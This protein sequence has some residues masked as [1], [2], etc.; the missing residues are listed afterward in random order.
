MA[1]GLSQKSAFL[2]KLRQHSS[3]TDLPVP[4]HLSMSPASTSRASRSVQ[5]LR[6]KRPESLEV[7]A[8]SLSIQCFVNSQDLL[9]P[10]RGILRTAHKPFA[11]KKRVQISEPERSDVKM[12]TSQLL[13]RIKQANLRLPAAGLSFGYLREVLEVYETYSYTPSSSALP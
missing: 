12:P 3:L 9:N 13:K 5:H 1:N 6:S 7:P 8:F 10:R 2:M 11:A 4:R